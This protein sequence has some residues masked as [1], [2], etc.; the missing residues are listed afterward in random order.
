MDWNETYVGKKRRGLEI[1]ICLFLEIGKEHNRKS[2]EGYVLED[3]SRTPLYHI[4]TCGLIMGLM[5]KLVQYQ[6]SEWLCSNY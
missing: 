2:F 5:V 3:L 6:D 1:K 4:L